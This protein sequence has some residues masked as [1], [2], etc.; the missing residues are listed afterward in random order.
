MLESPSPSSHISLQKCNIRESHYAF[1]KALGETKRRKERGIQ[2]KSRRPI[3]LPLVAACP[4]SWVCVQ[5]TP[6]WE[7]SQGSIPEEWGFGD[8][9]KLQATV[10]RKEL[11]PACRRGSGKAWIQPRHTWE[12]RSRQPAKTG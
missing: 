10:V 5:G 3:L 1:L 11:E 12:V 2:R 6:G 8:S 7:E 4:R 9:A